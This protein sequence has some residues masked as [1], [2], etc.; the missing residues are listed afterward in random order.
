MEKRQNSYAVSPNW[1][2]I[3]SLAVTNDGG[4]AAKLI[5]LNVLMSQLMDKIVNINSS[6]AIHPV[7]AVIPFINY[8][9]LPD[10]RNN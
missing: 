6:D 9:E 4:K 2:V 1:N 10:T 3:L 7:A 8:R 5:R